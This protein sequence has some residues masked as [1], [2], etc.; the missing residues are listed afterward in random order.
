M[1]RGLIFVLVVL[2]AAGSGGGAALASSSTSGKRSTRT[3]SLTVFAQPN[4]SEVGTPVTITG[5]LSSSNPGGAAVAL[6]QRLPGATSFHRVATASTHSSGRYTFVRAADTN[7]SWFTTSGGLRSSTVMEHVHAKVSLS[8]S[9]AEPIPGNRVRL[10]GKIVPSHAGDRVMLQQREGSAWKVVASERLSGQ[11]RFSFRRS[12]PRSGRFTFRAALA[13]NVRNLLSYSL[14]F[15][16]FVSQIH[17]IKHVVIIMQENRSFD[18]YF[19]TF[20]GA[21]GIPGLAGNPGAVPCI[22]DPQKPQPGMRQALPRHCRRK[23]R[24][25]PRDS[26]RDCGYGLFKSSSLHRLPDGR[27]RHPVRGRS[28]LQGHQPIVQPL[29]GHGLQLVPGRDGLP[30]RGGYPELLALRAGLRAAGPHV[31]AGEVVE[32]YGAPIH[33]LRVGREVL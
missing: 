22:P 5:R 17:K 28:A 14:P 21:D 26:Q 19:G 32:R 7:R 15:P 3:G 8:T 1:H 18:Q 16:L 11:S 25:P 10:M 20:R 27:V 4:P 9:N 6:W 23:L 33:G 29:P 2:A 13:A 31:R 30:H 24:R 12:F